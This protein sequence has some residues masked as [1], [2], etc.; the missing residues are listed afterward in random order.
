[1][2]IQSCSLGCGNAQGGSPVSCSLVNI[3]Q[4]AEVAIL[5]SQAVDLATVNS[6]SFRLVNLND[7]TVPTGVFTRD[8]ANP[9]RL[10]FRPSLTFVGAGTPEF[11]FAPNE[12]YEIRILGEGQDAGGPYIRSVGGKN[13][14]ARMVCTVQTTQP[15]IDPVPGPPTFTGYVTDQLTDGNVTFD[16]DTNLPV[17]AQLIDE[18]GVAGDLGTESRIVLIFDDVMNKATVANQLNG[19]SNTILVQIDEDGDVNT[20]GDRSSQAGEWTVNV[21]FDDL[22]RTVAIFEPSGGEFPTAG[23]DPMSP[24][25]VVVTVTNQLL[26][27]V[28]N[29]IDN[30]GQ[31]AF[32]TIT[33]VYD[34]QVLSVNFLDDSDEDR[35]ASGGVWGGGRLT[36]GPGGGSGRLGPLVLAQGQTL[37][38]DTDSQEFPLDG[39]IPSILSNLQPGEMPGDADYVAGDPDTWPTVTIDQIGQAFEFTRVDIAPGAR[40]ILT[41][42]QAA[43][44][45]A[46]GELVVSGVLDL[47]GGTPAP[48]VSNS[49]GDPTSGNNQLDPLATIDGGPGGE[50]GPAAGA[51]GQGADRMD[52]TDSTLPQMRNV[53]GALFPVGHAPA[54]N[55]GRD[56]G[57]IGGLPTGTGGI[58]GQRYPMNLPTCN[59]PISCTS[60]EYGDAETSFITDSNNGSFECRIA[61]VA[62]PGSGGSHAFAGGV[63]LP[64]SP[65]TSTSPGLISNIPAATAGG[66]N[67]PI[68]LESPGMMGPEA[69]RNLEYWRKH[70]RGGSGG[71]GGG[72]HIWGS[73]SLNNSGPGCGGGGPLFPFWDHSA[74]GGGGGGGAIMLTAGRILR[75][76]G[77]IDCSGGD[78]GSSTE[79]GA[80]INL[81]TQ[82]GADANFPPDCEKYASPGGGGAGGSVRLQGSVVEVANAPGRI[83]VTG[84]N[85]GSGVGGSLGGSGS[86]GLVRIEYNDFDLPSYQAT[87][88]ELAQWLVPYDPD[89]GSG[90]GELNEFSVSGGIMSLGEWEDQFLRPESFSGSQSCWLQVVGTFFSLEFVD[91]T[92]GPPTDLDN[93]GWNMDVVYDHPSEGELLFPY[94]GMPPVDPDDDYLEAFY[95]GAELGGDDFQTYLGTTLNH[96]EAALSSGSLFVV[97]FQ[98]VRTTGVVGDPCNLQLNGPLV[99]PDSVTPWVDHPTKLNL[100]SPRPNA[101]RFTVVFDQQLAQF[102]PVIADRIRGVTNLRV[103]VQPD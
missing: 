37:E 92:P 97:R 43:R 34:E 29:V 47:T 31:A 67:S 46:R 19:E 48:H 53:G 45:F 40:V 70:L 55:D 59:S 99:E 20:D 44:I 96:D 75:I 95:P 76:E 50:P 64:V 18:S 26:D 42:T 91:D 73:R 65:Y 94:R 8:A 2:Y 9:R 11:G 87:A 60:A 39:Q 71:G 13:N 7:G 84:G 89:A 102:D 98:G 5:F 30:P 12:T 69:Q 72:T 33:Q 100:F 52:V 10:I 4:N 3:A 49:G 58:G 101:I 6:G 17:G 35:G 88:A 90:P 56:G 81:C 21:D 28:G 66:D 25:R 1:M 61:M 103:R 74:A 16:P 22:L 54:V 38:L 63:G 23:G 57:G 86:A 24:R 41:G 80:S 32:S 83:V 93:F 78:G 27:I 85:G 79:P 82:S 14:Q 77:Q 68:D 62:G 36:Y 51:G 15:L